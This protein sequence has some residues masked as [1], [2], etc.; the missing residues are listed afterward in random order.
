MP[1][2]SRVGAA[3]EPN[4]D[5]AVP[6]WLAAAVAG[7]WGRAEWARWATRVRPALEERGVTVEMLEPLYGP[8]GR[9][10]VGVGARPPGVGWCVGWTG[11]RRGRSS[12]LRAVG[13]L[14]REL[15]KPRS[16]DARDPAAPG[17]GGAWM[18]RRATT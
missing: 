10:L 1:G 11:E 3:D 12:V 8:G 15:D 5:Q 9:V 2:R 4:G 17:A 13:Q 14:I 7:T 18:R 16:G 6:T